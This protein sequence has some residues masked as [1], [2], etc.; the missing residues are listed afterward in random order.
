MISVK[1]IPSNEKG[2]RAP[3]APPLDP[4][5]VHKDR[6]AQEVTEENYHVRLSHSKTVWKYLSGNFLV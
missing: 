5:M 3:G 6:N 4:R 1:N 2:G